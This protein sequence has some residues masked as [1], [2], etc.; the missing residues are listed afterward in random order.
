MIQWNGKARLSPYRRELHDVP[1]LT[2]AEVESILAEYLTRA[3]TL[4][5]AFAAGLLV[6]LRNG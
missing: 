6:G 3:G 2:L 5:F 1:M 4:L